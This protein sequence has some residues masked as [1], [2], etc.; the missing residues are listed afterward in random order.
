LKPQIPWLRVFVE[1]V[2][3]VGSILLAFG[4]QAGW[5][6]RQEW[7]RENQYLSQLLSDSRENQQRLGDALQLEQRQSQATQAVLNALRDS[8]P[9]SADSARAWEERRAGYYSDPRLLEGTMIALAET[10]DI[11]LIRSSLIRAGTIAYLSQLRADQAEFA[12]WVDRLL[13]HTDRFHARAEMVLTPSIAP[14]ETP[15]VRALL[16][17]Q[18]DLEARAAYVGLVTSNR[19]R[20]TYLED[21]LSATEDFISLL[22]APDSENR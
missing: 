19:N 3:I 16:A 4:I 17:A 11:N 22:D 14:D 18:D 9:I 5:E 10:G 20:I 15:R 2:V 8:A 1:G 13:E 21:M 12:R 6:V 7:A